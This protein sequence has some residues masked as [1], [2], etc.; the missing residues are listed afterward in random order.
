MRLAHGFR[1]AVLLAITSL[2][3][4]AACS[5]SASP[6]AGGIS[7]TGAW[8]RNSTA[9]TGALAGYVVI[10]N[11]GTD[12]DTLLSASSPIAKTVQLHETVAA[13]T[14][15]AASGMGSGMP[16]GSS[17]AAATPGMGQMM[18]MVEVSKVDIPAGG[19][20]EFKPG[21]YHIMFMDLASTPA[22]GTTVPLTLVFAKAGSITVQ[23]EVRAQ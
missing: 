2:A 4:V 12:A 23:A 19:T 9:V 22:A 17:S 5:A 16:T 6:S 21:G 20:V 14:A 15:P 7:V 3:L 8:I 10:T 13:G 18:T 1:R 11:N